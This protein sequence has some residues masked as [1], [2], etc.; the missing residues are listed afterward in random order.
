LVHGPDRDLADAADLEARESERV[1]TDGPWATDKTLSQDL[2]GPDAADLAAAA[3]AMA[4]RLASGA[5]LFCAAPSWPWHARHV[6]SELAPPAEDRRPPIRANTVPDGPLWESLRPLAHGGDIL[7]AVSGSAEAALTGIRQRT[8][9]WGLLTVWIGVGPRPEP[10]SADYVLWSDDDGT[11]ASYGGRLAHV[12]HLLCELTLSCLEHPRV[13]AS[14]PAACTDEVCITCSDE[15]RLGEVVKI[16]TDGRAEVRT[17][18]GPEEVDT[19]LIE[20]ARPG[21]LVL[22]HAGLALALVGGSPR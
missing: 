6:A 20:T 4:C 13:G 22:I 19:T 2:L 14:A 9:A 7:L 15:G 17:A 16:W 18:D 5:T 1:S 21:D 12:I 3:M 10:G 8:E 11:A